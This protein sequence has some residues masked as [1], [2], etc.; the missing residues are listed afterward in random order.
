L[1]VLNTFSY[2]RTIIKRAKNKS[3]ERRRSFRHYAAGTFPGVKNPRTNWRHKE[4]H[5]FGTARCKT[6]VAQKEKI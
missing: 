5:P 6:F 3:S 2:N 1:F 4:H